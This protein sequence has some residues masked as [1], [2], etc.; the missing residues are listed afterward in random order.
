LY[1]LWSKLTAIETIIIIKKKCRCILQKKH[2]AM[3]GLIGK[4]ILNSFFY[5]LINCIVKIVE[6]NA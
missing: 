1:S 5:G 4:K 6:T 3:K 2:T